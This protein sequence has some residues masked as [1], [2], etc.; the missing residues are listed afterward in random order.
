MTGGGVWRV[1]G[2][3]NGFQVVYQVVADDL[4]T[5][6]YNVRMRRSGRMNSPEEEFER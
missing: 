4:H 2:M 3:L 1:N 6:R 5:W